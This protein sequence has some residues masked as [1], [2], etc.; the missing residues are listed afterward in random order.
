MSNLIQIELSEQENMIVQIYKALHKL[1]TKK[2]AIKM[3]IRST[4]TI[5]NIN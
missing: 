1:N 3:L 4:K 5:P 2:E